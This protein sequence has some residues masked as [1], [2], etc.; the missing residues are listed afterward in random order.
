MFAVFLGIY[1]LEEK[2]LF[3]LL[4]EQAKDRLKNNG[5]TPPSPAPPPP[6]KAGDTAPPPP[7]P[8]PP[9]M[10]ESQAALEKTVRIYLSWAQSMYADQTNNIRRKE[11]FQNAK[12]DK[13]ETVAVA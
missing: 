2:Y 3:G 12:L 9:T 7:P 6:P 8:P 11:A 1:M 10:A 4:N 13:A 5:I